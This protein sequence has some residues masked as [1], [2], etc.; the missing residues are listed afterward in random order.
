VKQTF[1]F[2]TDKTF[3]TCSSMLALAVGMGATPAQASLITTSF[4]SGQQSTLNSGGTINFG[5]SGATSAFS[6]SY[7]FSGPFDLFTITGAGNSEVATTAAACGTNCKLETFNPGGQVD[8]S[9]NFASSATF[10]TNG[11]VPPTDGNY[12]FGLDYQPNGRNPTDT[13]GW[14]EITLTGGAIALDE[15]AFESTTN[16]PAPIPA[17]T[18]VPEPGTLSLFAVGA[19]AV[20]ARRKRKKAEAAA[21]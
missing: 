2:V 20:L 15:F 10:K 8:G 14:A 5:P 19:A 6:A 7:G 17:A 21:A 11:T 4:T 18:A 9:D 3:V 1:A 12:Y 13:Y 16:T